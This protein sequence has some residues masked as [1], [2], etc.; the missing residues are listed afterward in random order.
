MHKLDV[1]FTT[2]GLLGSAKRTTISTCMDQL[3]LFDRVLQTAPQTA[4]EL[5]EMKIDYLKLQ[6]LQL[7]LEAKLIVREEYIRQMTEKWRN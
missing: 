2:S 3:P 7:Q 1:V 4:E 5:L 6:C